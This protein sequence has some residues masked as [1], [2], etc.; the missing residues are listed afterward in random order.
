M[1]LFSTFKAT[2][3][4]HLI[5]QRSLVIDENLGNN[6]GIA[7]KLNN[8]GIIYY[9][10]ADYSKALE[11][12]N[13]CLKIGEKLRN[14][15]AYASTLLTNIGAIH[16]QQRDYPKALEYYKRS[17][18][19]DEKEK[20]QVGIAVD[21]INIGENYAMQGSYSRAEEHY[22]RSL[23]I[24]VEVGEQEGMASLLVNLGKI[25]FPQGDYPRALQLCK[26]GLE[27]AVK[28]GTLEKQK[29][30]CQCLYDTYKTMGRGNEALIYLEKIP[31]DRGFVPGRK[32]ARMLQR[33]EFQKLVLQDSI[34]TAEEKRILAEG[35]REE[36]RKKSRTKTYSCFRYLAPRSRW[37]SV[38]PDAL[39]SQIKSGTAGRKRPL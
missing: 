1:E 31:R 4:R 22:L 29:L 25:Y 12:Y 27:L 21:L 34:A 7:A 8:I 6:E 14:H 20:N 24:F 26:K 19:I 36:V 3:P 17:L 28:I 15:L 30:A 37:W 13:R 23:K 10:Q 38:Q 5:Y 18:E 16:H 9:E 39:Y 11:Y 32:T 33:M 2:T 35:H